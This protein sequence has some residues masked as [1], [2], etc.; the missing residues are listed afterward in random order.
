[1]SH[2]DKN[3]E[4]TE[5]QKKWKGSNAEIDM[6]YTTGDRLKFKGISGNYS[7]I[8]T[9]IPSEDKT[10]TFNFI[11]CTDID[12]NHYSVVEIGNKVWMA[13]NLKVTK[14]ADGTAI[15][16]VNS[17]ASWASLGDNDTDDA[18]CYYDDDANSIYGALYTTAA[19]MNGAGSS[20]N[21][22]SGV[23]G[24]CP[25]SWHLPSDLE[26]WEVRGILG[27]PTAAGQ[28]KETGTEHW[29]S[30]NTG[31]TN[32]SGFTAL[33]GGDRRSDNGTFRNLSYGGAWHTTYHQSETN[34]L[35]INLVYLNEDIKAF[36]LP[37]SGAY[38][39]R[40]VKD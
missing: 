15:P 20:R 14:Y 30:P 4:N 2:K 37:K 3:S 13:E 18:F 16:L 21:N 8:K 5:V 11:A 7:T 39:V 36:Y 23:Q 33:P 32:E 26:W 1:M 35:I 27:L 24:V 38:S 9:D 12:N 6:E 25:D 34:V 40:C 29:A 10:I 31:A 22:P 28:M 19:A 17:N